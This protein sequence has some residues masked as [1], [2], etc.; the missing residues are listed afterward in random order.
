MLGGVYFIKRIVQPVK[1]KFSVA[2]LSCR[3]QTVFICFVE[4]MSATFCLP[5]AINS[6]FVVAAFYR[7][8]GQP[9]LC[10]SCQAAYAIECLIKLICR[11]GN[12]TVGKQD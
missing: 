6:F 4:L 10:L 9:S 8:T 11:A 1:D 3:L 5:F 2:L 12:V 7:A